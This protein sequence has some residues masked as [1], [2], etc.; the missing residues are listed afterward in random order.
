VET[1]GTPLR[2]QWV[3]TRPPFRIR[4]VAGAPTLVLMLV[5]YGRAWCRR[6]REVW[7]CNRVSASSPWLYYTGSGSTLHADSARSVEWSQQCYSHQGRRSHFT[8]RPH[9]ELHHR[10]R[11][12]RGSLACLQPS[13]EVLGVSWLWLL[14]RP[15]FE[16]LAVLVDSNALTSLIHY[17]SGGSDRGKCWSRF[18]CRCNRW[19]LCGWRK[20]PLPPT[21]TSP[22]QTLRAGPIIN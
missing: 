15:L 10:F 13:E 3:A 22:L 1:A 8:P 21:W 17:C 12:H 4:G 11:H 20:S 9:L 18:L 5:G 14:L 19:W 16:L 7:S 2:L 6:G